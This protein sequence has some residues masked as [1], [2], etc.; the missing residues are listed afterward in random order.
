MNHCPVTL[1]P[2][3]PS[4]LRV[5]QR[6]A[7]AGFGSRRQIFAL[8]SHDTIRCNDEPVSPL[9]W[10]AAEDRL[11]VNGVELPTCKS[12]APPKVMAWHKPVGID[13]NVRV[14][15]ADSVW[16]KLQQL[17]LPLHPVGRLDKDSEGLLLLSQD[18]Q[19]THRLMS[20]E[21]AHEKLYQVRF[22]Q[23][24]TPQQLALL[25]AGPVYQ[26]GPHVYRPKPCQVADI[27]SQTVLIKLTEGKH[28]QIRYMSRAVGLKVER[29]TRIA[30]GA[31]ELTDLAADAVRD[32]DAAQIAQLTQPT[33]MTQIATRLRMK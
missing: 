31:Y 15:R 13:C 19:L 2:L 24:F 20:P 1:N 11:T 30:I 8:F 4:P 9:S 29:L 22:H 12:T 26:V 16:A 10:C 7:Q 25:T 33:P 3:P 28:R 6:L 23:P 5:W 27:D 17:A 32:L 18:G 21:F 14:G